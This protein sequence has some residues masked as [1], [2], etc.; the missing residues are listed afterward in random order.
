[1]TKLFRASLLALLLIPFCTA[2]ASAEEASPAPDKKSDERREDGDRRSGGDRERFPFAEELKDMSESDA[3]ELVE[4]YRLTRLTEILDLSEEQ[5]VVMVRQFREFREE[6]DALMKHRFQLLKELK[7]VMKTTKDSAQI[8]EKIAALSDAELKMSDLR[9]ETFKKTGENLT[10]EQRA[11]LFIFM[12]EFEGD[13]RRMIYQIRQRHRRPDDSRQGD[14]K[15]D[16]P[17]DEAKPASDAKAESE[18]P[19]PDKPEP[20]KP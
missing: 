3:R 11:K 10:S 20:A 8:E 13:V 1:M 17:K 12:S 6:R 7:E 18:K 16:A 19:E 9:R 2:A 5:T 4:T 14:G 15:S